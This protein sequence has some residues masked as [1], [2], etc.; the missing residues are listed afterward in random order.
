MSAI[1]MCGSKYKKNEEQSS[2]MR[3]EITERYKNTFL[4]LY[5]RKER[6]GDKP[7]IA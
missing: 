5:P 7:K 6:G 2:G 3:V 4:R 1:L